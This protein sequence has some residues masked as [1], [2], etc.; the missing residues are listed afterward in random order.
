MRSRLVVVAVAA[1]HLGLRPCATAAQPVA[2]SEAPTD[3]VHPVWDAYE[4]VFRNTP[5]LMPIPRAIESR[6]TCGYVLVPQDRADPATRM[7]R[8]SVVRVK[9]TSSDPDRTVVHL[10]GGPGGSAIDF[11]I[12]WIGGTDDPAMLPSVGDLVLA[13]ARGTGYSEPFVCR[14]ENGGSFD[15]VEARYREGMARCLD[16]AEARGIAL[17]TLSTWHI[18]LDT[19]D[20]RRALGLA[21]WN[22]WG[23]SYG[24]H[25]ATTVMHVDRNGV[26]SVL[27]DSTSPPRFTVGLADGL[28]SALDAIGQACAEHARCATDIGD[29]PGRLV[30]AIASYD[31][32]PLVIQGVDD[33]IWP[34]GLRIDGDVLSS[35]LFRT[36]YSWANLDDLPAML[37]VLENRNEEAIRGAALSARRAPDPLWGAAMAL[38]AYCRWDVP[39]PESLAVWRARNPVLDRWPLSTDFGRNA[40]DRC[41]ALYR[42]D[43]DPSARPLD[44]EIPTLLLSGAID[45]V[46]PPASTRAV[47]AALSR[48]QVIEVPYT[49][50]HVIGHLNR[51]APGCGTELLGAFIADPNAPAELPCSAAI[52]PPDFVTRLRVTPRPS[53]LLLRVLEGYRPVLPAA[54]LLGLLF[55]AAAFPLAAVGRRLDGR[56]TDR[57][58]TRVRLLAWG[59]AALSVAGTLV[60]VAAA[61]DTFRNHQLAIGVGWP[62][63]I[64]LA[65]WVAFAGVVLS[66][67]AVVFYLR[68]EWT[69]SRVVGTGAPE[70]VGHAGGDG[71]PTVSVGRMVGSAIGVAA[72][73]LCSLVVFWFLMS[74]GA[75]PFS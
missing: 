66:A 22:L 72:C 62:P 65:G 34:D 11:L 8:I 75:G 37:M 26:R 67:A 17:H 39:T 18:A 69:R 23:L 63:W 21:R 57:Q 32:E 10:A 16:D 35:T 9:G 56:R 7:L 59:G 31:D 13:D 27:L 42:I 28:R 52:R 6:I 74:V 45:P 19:R 70:R 40:R 47:A 1:V 29:L 46:T 71:G 58:L 64:A 53:R 73:A 25:L 61:A 38:V 36:V 60:M 43:A 14:G 20:V 3:L 33:S 15:E 44:S 49:G 24:T 30:D 12:P 48:A 2:V 68:L 5:C 50:H 41:Q 51:F 54:A 55:A 4:P